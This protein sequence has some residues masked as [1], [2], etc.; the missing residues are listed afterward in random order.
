MADVRDLRVAVIA[1]D[2]VEQPE[3]TEPVRALKQAGA[4]LEI[5]S[6]QAGDIQCF[7][8]HDKG[9]KVK[10]DKAVKDVRPDDYDALL[11][12]GGA[13]NADTLRADRGV[14][15]FVRAFDKDK[16]PMAIIC[17]APW[18]LIS[19]NVARGRTLTGYH[20]IEDDIR[21]AGAHWVDRE[22]A[23]DYNWV[24]SRQPSDLPAF[25]REML[26][27]FSQ[28]ARRTQTA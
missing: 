5:L 16:K 26:N 7:N 13:L 10:A 28:L 18:I 4:N 23:C 2:G 6:L 3:L 8:H 25:N 14:Q 12:P 11:L 15:A 27:T 24:T 21:N 17:H 1:T 20:T 19:A 22:V 9:D